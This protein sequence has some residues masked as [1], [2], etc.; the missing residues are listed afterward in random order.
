MVVESYFQAVKFKK[1]FEKTRVM[2]EMR[3]QQKK[4]L[5]SSFLP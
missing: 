3:V 2:D 5:K 1:N 4:K